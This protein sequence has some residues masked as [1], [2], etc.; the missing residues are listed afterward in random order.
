MSQ[1]RVR[2]AVV[3]VTLAGL[4]G[5]ASA[6]VTYIGRA[7]IGGTGTDFSNTGGIPLESGVRHDALDGFGSAIAYT[8]YQNRFMLAADRGP[9]AQAY[10]GGAAVDNTT[11]YRT[12]AQVFD[13]NFA[14]T[15]N[16]NVFGVNTNPVNTILFR[17]E[18]GQNLTGLSSGFT[19]TN[20]TNNLRLDPEGARVGRNG[21]IFVSDEYGPNVYEFNPATG[22][23]VRSFALP[24]RYYVSNLSGAGNSE[25]PA[26]PG[27]PSF[28]APGNTSGRQ[29]NRGMEGLA[30]SPDGTTL[31]GIMQSPLI[32]DGALNSGNS[33]RGV[34]NR[35]VKIDIAT[36]TTQEFVYQ[37]SN[38]SNGVNDMV[39]INDHEF[40]VI[41]RDG[42]GGTSA[43]TKT[44]HRI[45]ITGA[46]NISNVDNL[47]QTG[48]P[49]GITPVSN[50]IFMDFLTGTGI[51]A[52]SFD[53]FRSS[54]TG[55]LTFDMFP[56]KLEGVSFGPTLPDGRPTILVTN[57]NDFATDPNYIFAFAVNPN[58]LNYVPQQ[59]EH[60]YTFV[61]APS[62]AALLGLGGLVA[63]RRRRA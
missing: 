49:V 1:F 18:A 53:S 8:G 2:R 6:D 28:P 20:P 31:F 47:P 15:G 41:E 24:S 45:D 55:T 44:I 38:R 59:F 7:A 37:L 13:I 11:S 52:T 33:R 5:A 58:T 29:A 32:Q 63:G 22:E 39:A 60:D 51:E 48:L 34:N 54:L 21:H 36:G 19:G 40:L 42:N 43:V 61:P 14:P 12:R 25:L 50:S 17:N 56:E 9:N 27:N 57:D 16:P 10:P 23:R 30:I 35:I 3:L 62:A 26:I 46:T 4:T